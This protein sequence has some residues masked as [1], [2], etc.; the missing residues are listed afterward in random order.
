MRLNTAR[1]N[2]LELPVD[3]VID[4]VLNFFNSLEKVTI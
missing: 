3:E 1:S 4:N 2:W